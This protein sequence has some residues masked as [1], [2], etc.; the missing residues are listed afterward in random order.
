MQIP[1]T[2]RLVF[3]GIRAALRAGILFFVA[4]LIFIPANDQERTALGA[5]QRDQY[6]LGLREMRAAKT[7]IA[8]APDRAYVFVAT[9]MG[10]DISPL[11]VRIALI[12]VAAGNVLPQSVGPGTNQSS[13]NIE[14]PRFIQVD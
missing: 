2:F 3:H 12:Q 10:P 7:F 8:F 6:P 11:L 1:L 4:W 9:A 5:S 13:R 14:G